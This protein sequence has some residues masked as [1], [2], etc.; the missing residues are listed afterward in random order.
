MRTIVFVTI[1]PVFLS[2]RAHAVGLA[3]DIYPPCATQVVRDEA[4]DLSLALETLF[5]GEFARENGS[6]K[7]NNEFEKMEAQYFEQISHIRNHMGLIDVNYLPATFWPT[8]SG[9]LHYR[10]KLDWNQLVGR[11]V[12]GFQDSREVRNYFAGTVKNVEQ[13]RQQ[14]KLTLVTSDGIEREL[15]FRLDFLSRPDAQIFILLD[16]PRAEEQI[17][18]EAIKSANFEKIIAEAFGRPLEKSDY[19]MASAIVETFL[20]IPADW[21]ADSVLEILLG[22]DIEGGKNF[23]YYGFARGKTRYREVALKKLIGPI[24]AFM[25]ATKVSEPNRFPY[26]F[27]KFDRTARAPLFENY[28]HELRRKSIQQM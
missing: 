22:R 14:L 17:F 25:K 7:F 18:R 13:S 3:A 21:G 5:N 11:A 4:P 2:Y 24:H 23:T 1:L 26:W 8:H 10:R 16:S 20:H 12:T 27:A 19:E 9:G 6:H 15:N 28:W